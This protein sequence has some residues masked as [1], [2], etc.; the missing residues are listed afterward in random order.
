MFSVQVLEDMQP[1]SSAFHLL[2]GIGA[3][4]H[5]L[6]LKFPGISETSK[7]LCRK[8]TCIG[9]L[10]A[11]VMKCLI[12]LPIGHSRVSSI[13]MA[14]MSK[15]I[16]IVTLH[17]IHYV[18]GLV[19]VYACTYRLH[20]W[21]CPFIHLGIFSQGSLIQIFNALV[22][23]IVDYKI[24]DMYNVLWLVL[25]R[26]TCVMIW[27]MRKILLIIHSI[28]SSLQ[29]E[30]SPLIS[31]VFHFR[32]VSLLFGLLVIDSFFVRRSWISLTT[33]GPSVEIVFGLEVINSLSS[34]PPSLPISTQLLHVFKAIYFCQ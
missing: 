31:W 10:H 8:C 18:N 7:L 17:S 4:D 14:V 5:L 33:R 32:A 6:D 20:A 13:P 11:G 9:V 3:H 30:R 16:H 27:R 21:V 34:P 29:M 25:H 12:L 19:D 22:V 1:G 26:N 15:C 23:G 24:F 2:Y 28:V